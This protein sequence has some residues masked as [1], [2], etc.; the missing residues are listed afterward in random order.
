MGSTPIV[1]LFFS[2]LVEELQYVD[3]DARDIVRANKAQGQFEASYKSRDRLAAEQRQLRAY[4]RASSLTS[5]ANGRLGDAT[6]PFARTCR[7][8]RASPEG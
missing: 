6:L 1:G 4:I 2:P 7:D 8:S 3:G 5:D